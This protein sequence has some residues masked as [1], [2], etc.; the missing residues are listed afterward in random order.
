MSAPAK[1]PAVENSADDASRSAGESAAPSERGYPLS[2]Q[3][4]PSVR[5]AAAALT[6]VVIC[7]LVLW[8]ITVG[9][10]ALISALP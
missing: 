10:D 4:R 6:G 2:V 8:G 7:A 1:L 5:E 3:H 9:A